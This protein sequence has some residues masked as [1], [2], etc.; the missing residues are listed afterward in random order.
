MLVFFTEWNLTYC[1]LVGEFPKH[2]ANSAGF[3]HDLK[4]TI[5]YRCSVI[6]WDLSSGLPRP[7]CILMSCK[8]THCSKQL[9]N[10]LFE[11]SPIWNLSRL[12]KKYYFYSGLRI[13]T[14]SFYFMIKLSYMND[15][16]R[17]WKY[18]VRGI[19]YKLENK[20]IKPGLLHFWLLTFL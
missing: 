20:Y 4:N 13:A 10:Q 12:E 17:N 11:H 2:E 5:Y 15:L 1:L 9:G 3:L 16:A 18:R 8:R 14:R 19:I 7:E 6:N